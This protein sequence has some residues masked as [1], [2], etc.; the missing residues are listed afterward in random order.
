[1]KI[2]RIPALIALAL[3]LSVGLA[4]AETVKE[5]T[6]AC[7]S[8]NAKS[9]GRL[10]M[11]Y[12]NG[13][14]VKKS[15]KDAAV[16]YRKACELG[17]SQACSSFVRNYVQAAQL[18]ALPYAK[19]GCINGY[20]K[21]CR[22]QATLM[23]SLLD[24]KAKKEIPV[25]LEKACELKDAAACLQYAKLIRR[26]GAKYTE[27]MKYKNQACILGNKTACEEIK[28]NNQYFENLRKKKSKK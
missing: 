4:N 10:A 24:P 20:G 11:A 26:S 13:K 15:L 22:W 27:A 16:F 9:C 2:I 21:A 6:E 5:T 8:G 19:K 23:D 12:E 3:S 14:G 17:R 18:E 1:M 28:T 7:E 25:L